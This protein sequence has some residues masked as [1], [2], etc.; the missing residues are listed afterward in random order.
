VCIFANEIQTIGPVL[1]KFG[2]VEEHDPGKFLCMFES[3]L[4]LTS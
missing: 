3:S 4:D 2:T 1:I